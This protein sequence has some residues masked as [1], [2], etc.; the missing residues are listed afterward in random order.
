MSVLLPVRPAIRV[1]RNPRP[2]LVVECPVASCLELRFTPGLVSRW[3]I[4]ESPGHLV[5]I[6][7]GDHQFTFVVFAVRPEDEPAPLRLARFRSDRECDVEERE[8]HVLPM[9]C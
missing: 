8:L 2:G 3:R 9:G 4:Q 6:S 7:Q 5:A 1:V